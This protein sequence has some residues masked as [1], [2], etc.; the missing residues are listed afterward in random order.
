L[1]STSDIPACR[2]ENVFALVTRLMSLFRAFLDLA[3]YQSC[4]KAIAPTDIREGAARIGVAIK[5]DRALSRTKARISRSGTSPGSSL[6]LNFL[7]SLP[8]VLARR[9]FP[10][11]FRAECDYLDGAVAT[12]SLGQVT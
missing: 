7:F 3:F 1:I 8:F 6:P 9:W 11:R 12:S 2:I 5:S 10:S 4:G